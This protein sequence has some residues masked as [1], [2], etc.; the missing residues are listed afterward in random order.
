MIVEEPKNGAI[1]RAAAISDPSV[2]SPTA[3]TSASSGSR[4]P[5]AAPGL[6]AVTLVRLALEG[7]EIG[8][9]RAA[10]RAVPVLGDVLER[11]PRIDAAVGV[12][13]FG[14]VDETAGLADPLP[15][16]VRRHARAY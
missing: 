2:L 16:R 10:D 3:T 13:L 1:S 14:V 15:G 7:R 9:P 6:S 5:R 12:A 8:L 4:S 11:R